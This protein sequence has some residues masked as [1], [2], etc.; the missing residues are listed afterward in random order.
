MTRNSEIARA[1]RRTLILSAVATAGANLPIH[2]QDQ[3]AQPPPTVQTVTVTGSRIVAPNQTSISPVTVLSGEDIVNTGRTRVEDVLNQLP[4]I[5]GSQNSGVSNG[6][7]GTALVNLRNLDSKRTLVL[8]NGRRLGPGDPSGGFAR[9][10][11]GA[12]VNMIPETLIERVDVLTGGASS[13]YGADAVAGVVN[14]VMNTHFEGIKVQGSYGFYDHDNHN[15]VNSILTNSI[16]PINVPGNV[17]SG[18]SKDVSFVLGMNTPDNKGNATFFATYRNIAPILQAPFDYSGCTLS[19]GDTFACGGSSTS[20]P[21]NSGGRFNLI[22]NPTLGTTGPSQT[23]GPGGSLVPYTAA[24]AYNFGA[25]NYFQRPDERYTAGAFIHYEVNEHAD[26]YNELMFMRD[27]TTSQIAPSGAFY[28]GNPFDPNANGALTV[29]CGN[30]FL[31]AAE[32][33]AWCGGATAGNA[34][35]LIGRRNVEGGNRQQQLTHNDYRVVI[36]S[37]GD[38]NDAWKYDVFGQYGQ[39]EL[40]SIYLNDVSWSNVQNSL[41]VDNVNGVPTCQSVTSGADAR[42]VPWNIFTP[43]GVTPAATNYLAIPLLAK[44]TVTERVVNANVTG[45]LGKYGLQ[46]PTAKAGLI[47]NAGFEYRQEKSDF[48]PDFAFINNLGAGQGGATLPI[49]GQYSVREGF[50]EARMPLLEDMPLAKE[51]AA[52]AGYRYSSYS[53]NFKTNTYKFGLEWSPLEDVRLRGTFQR[54][55]RVPNVGELFSPTQVAL[56]GVTDPC[57]GP[58][59]TL[60]LAQCQRTGVTPAQYGQIDSN[61]VSQY[62]GF[63][64]GN[65]NLKPETAITKSVGIS[66]TPTFADGLRVS[67]DYFDINIESAI[68]N[69]NADF[70]LINCAST[71][72]PLTCGRIHRSNNGSLWT[73]PAGFV[74]DQLVNIGSI[75]TRGVDIDSAYRLRLGEMGRLGNMGRL[76]F[77]FVG[78]YTDKGAV[79]PQPGATYECSGFY[80]GICQAPLPKWRHVFK[81]TWDTPVQGLDVSLTWRYFDSVKLDSSAPGLEFLGGAYAAAAGTAGPPATDLHLSSISYIDMSAGY[82]YDKYNVRVGVNNL[83]DKDPPINGSTTCPAGPCNGN[84]WPVVY[85]VAGRYLYVMLTAEF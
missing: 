51:L 62:N 75:S 65:P 35:L 72:N 44:G 13:V 61:P 29:N 12:D 43:G 33:G 59:P 20:G 23:I 66:F 71:G 45:D 9:N 5:F 3:P 19:S 78:T 58:A 37:R 8:I 49:A 22:T 80:G 24:N 54:A 81:T 70:T 74:N 21:P 39:I 76:N 18:F 55:V 41:L 56:D 52:E 67:V 16:P 30:P 25:L 31:S 14:F 27:D 85:D 47:V 2:A 83:T 4:Q 15:A 77:S 69:P 40:G 17:H 42:C 50:L 73:S 34:Q 53:L 84:T 64:G 6:A 60:T 11:Y 82:Q 7:N 48:E 26:V 46:M 79:S 38:I 10:T 63:I 32:L 57:A 68:Q 1:V 36:G 28:G